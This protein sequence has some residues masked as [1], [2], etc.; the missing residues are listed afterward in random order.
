MNVES[1]AITT[2]MYISSIFFF[3]DTIFFFKYYLFIMK[4]VGKN[5]NVYY[6]YYKKKRGRKKKTGPKRKKLDKH[7]KTYDGTWNYKILRFDF[8]KQ[9]EYIG[10]YRTIEDL[11]KKR[12]ELEEL[13]ASVEM[14]VKYIVSNG[15]KDGITENE[16]EYVILKRIRNE[17]ESNESILRN[18]YG[19]LVK[20]ITTSSRYFIYDKFPCIKEETFWVYGFNPKADRKTYKWIYSSFIDDILEYGLTFINIYVYGNKLIFRYDGNHIELVICKNI[21]DSI[22][23]YNLLM[24]KYKKNKCVLFRGMIKGHTDRGYDIIRLIEEK[25]GWT[26]KKIYKNTTAK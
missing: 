12:S 9:V 8:K 11:A 14:P 5:G 19:K 13:N 16:S 3:K 15:K 7:I 20:H 21:S 22:R 1:N 17:G 25:T 4:R 6:T 26:K 24:E 23:M 10:T 18:Q 2:T